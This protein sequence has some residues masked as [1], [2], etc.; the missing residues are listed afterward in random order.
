MTYYDPTALQ[1]VQNEWGAESVSFRDPDPNSLSMF[2]GDTEMLK[3][4]P[5]GFWVRGV[6]VP[7]DEKEAE[8]VYNAFKAFLMW[9]ELNRR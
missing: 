3:V 1:K 9:A 4:A 7:A 5:D 8:R 6:K 2:V